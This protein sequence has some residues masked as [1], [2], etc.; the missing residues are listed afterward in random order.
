MMKKLPGVS[1]IL[2]SV[3][4]TVTGY[5]FSQQSCLEDCLLNSLK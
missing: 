5:K 2:K 1:K 3:P 4:G